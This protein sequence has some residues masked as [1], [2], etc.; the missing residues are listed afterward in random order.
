[1]G[2]GEP[3]A[4]MTESLEAIS[5]SSLSLLPRVFFV[6]FVSP[7]ASSLI[8]AFSTVLDLRHLRRSDSSSLDRLD[9]VRF[10]ISSRSY[11]RTS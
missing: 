9:L 6:S 3:H 1:M 8:Q 7:S 10:S 2:M 5:A 11:K 4:H